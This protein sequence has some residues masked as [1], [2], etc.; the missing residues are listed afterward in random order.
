MRYIWEIVLHI[1][2]SIFV[3]F[4]SLPVCA[5]SKKRANVLRL[6]NY[7]CF[8]FAFPLL[9]VSLPATGHPEGCGPWPGIVTDCKSDWDWDWDWALWP[10]FTARCWLWH[11]FGTAAPLRHWQA[12]FMASASPSSDWK[13][14]S[15]SSSSGSCVDSNSSDSV[16]KAWHSFS[17]LA[18]CVYLCAHPYTQ[19]QI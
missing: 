9:L 16:H 14:G 19:I 15:S 7:R 17:S 1:S 10:T 12:Q 2:H 13:C 3:A 5:K 4:S 11:K 18:I 8:S 6:I